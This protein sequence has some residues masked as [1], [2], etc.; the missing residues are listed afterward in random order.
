[1]LKRKHLGFFWEF[2]ILKSLHFQ[3]WSLSEAVF[4]LRFGFYASKTCTR[5]LHI[6]GNRLFPRFWS[7]LAQSIYSISLFLNLTMGLRPTPKLI[8][9]RFW[10]AFICFRNTYGSKVKDAYNM[11]WKL[12]LDFWSDFRNSGFY[13]VGFLDDFWRGFITL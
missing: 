6:S 9:H 11:L 13:L 4:E 2:E 8:F 5:Y 1:M 10:Y 7:E 12:I 3:P